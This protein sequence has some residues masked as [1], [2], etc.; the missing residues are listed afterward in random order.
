MLCV[1]VCVFVY[2]QCGTKK[3]STLGHCHSHELYACHTCIYATHSAHLSRSLHVSCSCHMHDICLAKTGCLQA[4][5]CP[6]FSLAATVRCLFICI[7]FHLMFQFHFFIHLHSWQMSFVHALI[8]TKHTIT[9]TAMTTPCYYYTHTPPPLLVTCVCV[10]VCFYVLVAINFL[11]LFTVNRVRLRF[12][13]CVYTHTH[14]HSSVWK[15]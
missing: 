8:A 5:Q 15:K 4:M 11:R 7:L 6:F 12:R 3:A 2:I 10:Y 13:K 14:T 1:C 9:N